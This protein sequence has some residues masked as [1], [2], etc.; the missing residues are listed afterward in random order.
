MLNRES[1]IGVTF[2]KPGYYAFVSFN[3]SDE[4]PGENSRKNIN[5]R[6]AKIGIPKR[7]CRNLTSEPIKGRKPRR[8]KGLNNM[9]Q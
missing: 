2:S 5:Y 1:N 3:N 7:L 8:H 6:V 9:K 4:Q